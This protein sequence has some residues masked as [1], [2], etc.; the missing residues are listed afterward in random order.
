M[1]GITDIVIHGREIRISP[2]ELRASQQ[3][4]LR[5]LS[6]RAEYREQNKMIVLPDPR[7]PDELADTVLSLLR[8]LFADPRD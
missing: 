4:G 8:G 5:R 7:S 3:I 1:L 2:V 6:P